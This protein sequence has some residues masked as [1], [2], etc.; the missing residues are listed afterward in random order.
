M[1]TI[2]MSA[3]IVTL[4]LGGPD[5][6]TFHFVHWLWPILWFLGKTGVFLFVYVWLRA[7][8]PR[9]RYDQLMD[10]GWKRLIPVSLLWLLVIAGML[11]S[12]KWG[13]S[14]FGGGVVVGVLVM[15]AMAVGS[16]REVDE[17]AL[18]TGGMDVGGDQAR[19]PAP[20]VL[21]EPRQPVARSLPWSSLDVLAAPARAERYRGAEPDRGAEPGRPPVE[22]LDSGDKGGA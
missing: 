11:I 8:L 14:V 19:R 22:M 10:L 15:R 4:F 21:D 17:F 9:L 16:S 12:P 13:L 5:G 6:P 18:G 3:I 1:N 2:T 7:T 20:E